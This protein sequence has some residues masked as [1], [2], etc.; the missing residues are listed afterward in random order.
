MIISPDGLQVDS[1]AP[2][3]HVFAEKGFAISG[4]LCRK[5]NFPGTIMY[6]YEVTHMASFNGQ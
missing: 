4:A 2:F 1:I 6:Y 3:L 5:D